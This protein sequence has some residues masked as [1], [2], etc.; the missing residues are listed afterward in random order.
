VEE[1][2]TYKDLRKIHQVERKSPSLSSID[3][4]FYER[5]RKYI[6][7]LEEMIS[8]ER[9]FQKRRFLEDELKNALQTFNDIYELREKKIVQA[10]LSKVRGGSPDLKNLI[11]EE[12]D[13]FDKM[14]ENLSLFRE[15]LL[16]G[17]VEEKK[18]EVEKETI[19]KQVILIKEDIPTFVGTDMRKYSLKK[20]DVVSVDENL[21]LTLEKRGVGERVQLED[22][23]G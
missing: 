13:L 23:T 19:K 5:A 12:R 9:N 11:P 16:L 10:A 4:S 8:K 21:C 17:K 14:V 3:F 7:N 2:F 22:S 18:E 1:D 15:K 20:G 6:G